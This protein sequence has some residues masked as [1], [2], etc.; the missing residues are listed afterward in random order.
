MQIHPHLV[1]RLAPLL[2][3]DPVDAD[4]PAARA[5]IDAYYAS[6]AA[7]WDPPAVDVADDAVPGP[8]GDVPVRVYRPRDAVGP[9]PG[10][11]WLHG[12]AW[13]HGGLDMPEAHV[14]A[15]ELAVAANAVVVSVDYHLAGPTVRYPV[16]VDDTVAVW[17][18]VTAGRVAGL[19]PSR[20]ALGGAS[21]G[22]NIALGAALRL[23]DGVG[24]APAGLVLAYPVAHVPIPAPDDDLG[25]LLR[26]VPAV[27]RFTPARSFQA[28]A[29]YLGRI[30]DIPLEVSPG[31]AR[32]AGLPPTWLGLSEVDTLRPSGDLL[33][34]QLEAAGVPV[35]VHVAEGMLHGHLNQVPRPALPGIRATLDFLAEGLAAAF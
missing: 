5:L 10:L 35:R 27:L 29:T 24:A 7:P 13:V 16:P 1:P 4:T 2:A 33:A 12:G 30:D 6:L 31:H 17:E 25:E 11:V 21:A 14:V 15:A 34:V 22:G 3:I 23:R 9:L 18:H 20:V 32:L 26:Q 8:H 28:L 19:D